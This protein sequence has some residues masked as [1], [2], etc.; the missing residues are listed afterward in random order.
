MLLGVGKHFMGCSR[1]RNECA[2]GDVSV[3]DNC[4]WTLSG[5]LA[6][7]SW[8]VE[9]Y[10]H[11]LLWDEF[12]PVRKIHGGHYTTFLVHEKSCFCC[13]FFEELVRV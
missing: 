12:L 7:L 10:L 3:R 4:K 2:C 1:E 9:P 6:K 11:Y 13:S 8:S 5:D